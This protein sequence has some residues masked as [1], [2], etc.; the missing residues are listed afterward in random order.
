MQIMLSSFRAT[1]MPDHGYLLP[2]VEKIKEMNHMV[3]KK[4]R[5]DLE[6]GWFKPYS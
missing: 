6:T 2:P 5:I 1:R 4:I 3:K